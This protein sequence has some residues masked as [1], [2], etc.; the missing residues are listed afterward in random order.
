MKELLELWILH[1]SGTC[2]FHYSLENKVDP[3]LFGG[4][5]T[6][7]NQLSA[8][9]SKTGAKIQDISTGNFL[10]MNFLL[11][12]YH[13]SLVGRC[14]KTKHRKSVIKTLEHIA[15]LFQEKY[16]AIEVAEWDGNLVRFEKFQPIVEKYFNS[17]ELTAE[18]LRN[19]F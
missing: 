12:E 13:V 6:A 7:I 14:K 16:E 9:M 15:E 17:D 10:L 5:F 4:F 11:P 3:V 8:S 19:I 18:R 1:E 2:L